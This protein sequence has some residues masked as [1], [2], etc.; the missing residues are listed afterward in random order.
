MSSCSRTAA[1]FASFSGLVHA[2]RCERV[3]ALREQ[4]RTTL[5]GPFKAFSVRRVFDIPF[6]YCGYRDRENLI[7][8]DNDGDEDE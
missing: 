8:Y 1:D 5:L 3:L 2:D 6:L 7:Q 4:V